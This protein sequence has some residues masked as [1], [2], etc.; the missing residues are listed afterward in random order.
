[1]TEPVKGDSLLLSDPRTH[2]RADGRGRRA[3]EQHA[4]EKDNESTDRQ[5]DRQ[6]DLLS[7]NIFKV[8]ETAGIFIVRQLASRPADGRLAA[9][10]ALF[11]T[12]LWPASA[13]SGIS[14]PSILS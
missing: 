13:A 6:L 4:M 12:Y 3:D 14:W 5:T 11:D 10:C 9:P 2:G 1:M 8:G 7:P